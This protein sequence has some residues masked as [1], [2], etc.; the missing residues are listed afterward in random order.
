MYIIH[1]ICKGTKY[2]AI[3]NHSITQGD[4]CVGGGGSAGL[5]EVISPPSCVSSPQRFKLQ[6][7]YIWHYT[8]KRNNLMHQ[9]RDLKD[10]Q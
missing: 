4:V 10:I 5:R 1:V 7:H 3:H 2:T 8:M 9:L 6:H